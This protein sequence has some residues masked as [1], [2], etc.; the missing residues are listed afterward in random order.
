M[1]LSTPTRCFQGALL[2]L[3]AATV[4]LG[5]PSPAHLHLIVPTVLESFKDQDSRVRYYACEA[6]YNIAKVAREAFVAFFNPV[7][8]A[9]LRCGEGGKGAGGRG[10]RRGS[11]VGKKGGGQGG[12]RRVLQ[13]CV[14]RHVQVG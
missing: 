9:M 13:P 12:A 3:A 4:G 10:E 14:W 7:F 11:E 5:E 8:D 6:L 1:H 2:C